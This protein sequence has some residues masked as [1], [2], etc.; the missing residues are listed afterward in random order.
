MST[1]IGDRTMDTTNLP[2]DMKQCLAFHGHLCSGLAIG[3]CAAK[4]GLKTLNVGR[5]GDE[6]LI[7]IVENDTCAVDAIQV[8]TGCTFD[9]GNLYFRDYGKMVFTFAS[10][11]TGRSARLT[12][13]PLN[14]PNSTDMSE[15]QRR[16]KSIAFM[17]NRPPDELFAV[18]KSV[19]PR[20][21]EAARIRESRPCDYCGTMVMVTRLK[22]C[23]NL[24]MCIPCYEDY[25]EEQRRL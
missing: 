3:Y 14:A 13:Q 1:G 4:L 22:Q 19:L 7:A 20:L 18:Q 16:E 9:K 24:A 10:R 12:Y 21:P 23:D 25:L 11:A 2:D 17:I 5:A 6:E 8:L 15:S